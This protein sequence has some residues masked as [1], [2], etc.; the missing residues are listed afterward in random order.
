MSELE[1]GFN[2]AAKDERDV[3]KQ[4]Q[5]EYERAL[6]DV[7]QKE[8]FGKFDVT[9]PNSGEDTYQSYMDQRPADGIVRNSADVLV[10]SATNK[11]ASQ[12]AYEAQVG[13]TQDYYDKLGGVAA[14]QEQSTPPTYEEMGLLQLA[15]EASK[16]R[17][18]GDP[19][20]EATIRA[21]LEHH[22]T[23][24]ALKDDTET[25][26]QAQARY[27]ADLA[28]Y[29]QL[30]DRLSKR[31]ETWPPH[32]AETHAE[33]NGEGQPS[34]RTDTASEST[35]GD[36]AE[37][38]EPTADATDAANEEA[39]V[40]A[41]QEA[42]AP[43]SDTDEP[44]A[45]AEPAVAS[46]AEAPQTAEA[47]AEQ[48]AKPVISSASYNGKKIT[49]ARVTPDP[50]GNASLDML[51][52]IDEDGN[53]LTIRAS[54]VS[55]SGV[56]VKQPEPFVEKTPGT[57]V[58]LYNPEGREVVLAN[59]EEETQ[60]KGIKKWFGKIKA[61]MYRAAGASA[62]AAE[63]ARGGY[64]KWIDHN[65]N[66]SMND[67]E[68]EK[69]RKNNRTAAVIAGGALALIAVGGIGMGIA[70]GVGAFN[71][72]T[73]TASSGGMGDFA[74]QWDPSQHVADANEAISDGPTNLPLEGAPDVET[75]TDAAPTVGPEV[76]AI[77]GEG[78]EALF[79]RYEI[80]T[81]FYDQQWKLLEMFPEDF[82]LNPAGDGVWVSHSGALS[83]GAQDAINSLR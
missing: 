65:V 69:K 11:F 41:E 37:A 6:F 23:G 80:P 13:S 60:E 10:N 29:D 67:E 30:V 35:V 24:D 22:L 17:Q 16:A 46:E 49:V 34:N 55:Y 48:E 43:E 5:D 33:P 26:E 82:K 20:E 1:P 4:K 31:G 2:T 27:D 14:K 53:E 18:L 51:T 71:G 50:S 79:A 57:D 68:K 72:N 15:K 76:S 42:D 81:S 52:V 3:L 75:V 78:G 9:A 61:G 77:K 73:P 36:T 56:P 59:P 44:E 74:G 19:A 64:S 8:A 70:T 40:E 66:D 38:A 83:Q 28:R 63:W 7:Q 21:A 45:Q 62:W 25:A 58:E 47:D 12:E 54:D 39:P 32:A